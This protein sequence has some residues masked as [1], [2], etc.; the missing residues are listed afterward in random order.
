MKRVPELFDP[1]A[2]ADLLLPQ[3]AVRGVQIEVLLGGHTDWGAEVRFQ[4]GGLFRGESQLEFTL[5]AH[6][7]PS[8]RKS[9]P[10]GQLFQERVSQSMDPRA[11]PCCAPRRLT[12]LLANHL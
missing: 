3:V 7:L 6:R 12:K 8:I 1:Q 11:L 4:N 9:Q 5:E 2:Q 10:A